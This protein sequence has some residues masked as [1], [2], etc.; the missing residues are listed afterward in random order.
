MGAPSN[1]H[2]VLTNGIRGH[3]LNTV[4]WLPMQCRPRKPLQWETVGHCTNVMENTRIQAW[5]FPSSCHGKHE[6][7]PTHLH[8]TQSMK[9]IRNVHSNAT[10]VRERGSQSAARLCWPCMCHSGERP[11]AWAPRG[12]AQ[13][14]PAP[15]AREAPWLIPGQEQGSTDSKRKIKLRARLN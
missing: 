11:R 15:R 10:P 13:R 8:V 2:V 1:A 9:G 5:A 6:L 4:P 7:G 3:G 12:H 14:G